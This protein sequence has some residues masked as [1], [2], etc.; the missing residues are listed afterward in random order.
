MGEA[1]GMDIC[2]P[3]TDQEAKKREKGRGQG[4]N[5]PFTAT[6]S[7][8]H[9]PK[10]SNTSLSTATGDKQ[11]LSV[12]NIYNPNNQRAKTQTLGY[13]QNIMLRERTHI[14]GHML[15]ESVSIKCSERVRS[16]ET[17]RR[18]VVARARVKEY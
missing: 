1:C 8:A 13:I 5:I 9:L 3:D 14:E 4:P 7:M 2:S 10:G 16:M 6:P 15:C 18:L 11:V 12:W 17:E